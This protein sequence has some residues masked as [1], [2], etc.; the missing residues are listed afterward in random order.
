MRC[1]LGTI[2]FAAILLCLPSPAS[3]GLIYND[4]A[5]MTGWHG[6]ASYY[7]SDAVYTLNV[8]VDYAVYAPGNYTGTD[9]SNGS[10][11]VYV[12]QMM[13]TINPASVEVSTFRVGLMRGSQ[14]QDIGTDTTGPGVLAGVPPYSSIVGPTSA[15]W[16]FGSETD[17]THYPVI[18]YSATASS[19][20]SE[21][22]LFTSPFGPTWMSSTVA[23]GGLSN[24]QPLP[25]PV[26]EPATLTLLAVGACLGVSR[27]RRT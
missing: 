15:R 16:S 13:N 24:V 19:G 27:R 21:T 11:Y 17:P 1:L 14:A 6:Q 18:N 20:H 2:S 23:D 5:A 3:A 12:Y 10:R 7:A 25:S 4:P 26:P 8:E 9:P 22:L